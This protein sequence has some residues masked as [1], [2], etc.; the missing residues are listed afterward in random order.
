MEYAKSLYKTRGVKS[1]KSRQD[2]KEEKDR[3]VKRK[4]DELIMKKRKIDDVKDDE[5]D[6]KEN[7]QQTIK[8]KPPFCG[9]RQSGRFV[10]LYSYFWIF[11]YSLNWWWH[12]TSFKH[13]LPIAAV[14]R[15]VLCL[16]PCPKTTN[17]TDMLIMMIQCSTFGCMHRAVQYYWYI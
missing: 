5:E 11:G 13:I 15:V 17:D 8:G 6:A 3:E 10:Q 9:W 16:I 1:G 4:R 14:P 7:V 2:R 12:L